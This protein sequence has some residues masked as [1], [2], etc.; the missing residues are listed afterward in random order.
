MCVS[1][2]ACM[3]AHVCVCVCVCAHVCVCVC[4]C[5]CARVCV[6]MRVHIPMCA[7]TLSSMCPLYREALCNLETTALCKTAKPYYLPSLIFINN[8]TGPSVTHL[9]V[10]A[11]GSWFLKTSVTTGRGSGTPGAGIME[12]DHRQVTTVF[13]VQPSLHHRHW[14]NR[15]S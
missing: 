4:V 8:S 15:V 13:T 12:A 2:C 7:V 6:F 11:L 10:F 9:H 5:V 1:V 3:C 14:T